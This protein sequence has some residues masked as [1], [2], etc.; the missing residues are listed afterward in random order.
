M[1]IEV[2]WGISFYDLD[3]SWTPFQWLQETRIRGPKSQ[4]KTREENPK[5]PRPRR[6]EE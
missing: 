2:E 4:T 6:T 1:S 5:T 3:L